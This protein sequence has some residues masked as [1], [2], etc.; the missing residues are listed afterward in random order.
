MFPPEVLQQLDR[1]RFFIES[2][3]YEDSVAVIAVDEVHLLQ[4][5]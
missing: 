4:S 1:W 2:K 3:V 5:W